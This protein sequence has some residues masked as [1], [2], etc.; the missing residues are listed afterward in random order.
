VKVAGPVRLTNLFGPVS[1]Y[2]GNIGPGIQP[3]RVSNSC[4]RKDAGK[5]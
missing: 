4:V 3:A 5:E 1:F 2:R